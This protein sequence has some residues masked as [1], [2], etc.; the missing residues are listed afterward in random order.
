MTRMDERVPETLTILPDP[1]LFRAARWTQVLC[2]AVAAAAIAICLAPLF[3]LAENEITVQTTRASLPI[4]LTALVSVVG[5]GLSGPDRAGTRLFYAGRA[6][7]VLAIF[8]AAVIIF[9]T[10]AISAS[11]NPMH[12]VAPP[13]KLA[14]GFVLL[15]VAVLLVD[16]ANWL[17][18]RAVD[19]MV[20]GLCLLAVL[21]LSDVLFGWLGVFGMSAG[22]QLP[23]A[24]LVCLIALTTAVTLRQA[25]H[26]VLSIF[27]GVGM[28]SKM[29]RIFAPLLLVLTF[30]W[31]ALNTRVAGQPGAALL[32][33]GG[34]AVGTGILLFFA[35]RI[36]R[37]ENEIHDLVLRDEATR[38]YNQRGFHLLAEHALRLAKRT[39]VPFS[40]LFVE[41]ENLTEIH[42]E[43]GPNA[44]AASL[45]EA[46]EI[47]RATFRESDI[48]GRI[49]AADFA[50][51]GRF[52]RAGISIAALRLEAATAARMSKTQGPVPLKLSIGHVTTLDSGLQ[53]SLKDLLVRAGQ[54]KNRV[55]LQMSQML[56]N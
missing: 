34:V 29:A 44:A 23:R 5:L 25:E 10:R 53:E 21:I 45:A 43:L 50:V 51:A 22:R 13:A 15:A 6:A 3:G 46:G 41:M 39:N 35:W 7:Q 31:E 14:F 8:G 55:E 49:G 2:L 17:I 47:L 37:M 20:C 24:L 30:A 18:N 4:L 1:S 40:V 9:W 27:L 26:G 11:G 33:A 32:A 48:K 28:G 42:S 38:L 12:A 54:A 52:D 19:V 16:D 36:S 56:V